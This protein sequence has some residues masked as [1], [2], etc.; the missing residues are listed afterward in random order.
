MSLFSVIVHICTD[1][2]VVRS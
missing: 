1:N 2:W